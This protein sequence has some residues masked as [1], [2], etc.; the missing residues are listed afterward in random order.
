VATAHKAVFG[1]GYG[2]SPVVVRMYTK[3]GRYAWME[4]NARVVAMPGGK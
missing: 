2:R 1:D 4:I 3:S